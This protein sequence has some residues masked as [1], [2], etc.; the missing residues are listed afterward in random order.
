LNK[1]RKLNV[2]IRYI[3]LADRPEQPLE[4]QLI[5]A[6][7]ALESLKTTYAHSNHIPFV[8]GHFRKISSPPMR[9]LRREPRYRF[10][11]LLKLMLGDVKMGKTALKQL[12]KLR[13]TII[14]TGIA[15]VRP[16]TL[17]KMHDS[18]Q[19]ILREYLLRLLNYKG[20]FWRYTLSSSPKTI[21]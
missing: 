1:Q 19:D 5:L 9:N 13:N 6:F 10:E 18:V 2:V 20:E 7:V 17:H 16:R 3:L 4:V 15:N 11:D 21:K 8:G 12:I 14:H